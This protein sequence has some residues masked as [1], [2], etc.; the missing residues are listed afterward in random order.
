MRFGRGLEAA[1]S[2]G[3]RAGVVAI[4]RLA[5][6]ERLGVAERLG[7][8]ERLASAEHLGVEHLAAKSNAIGRRRRRLRMFVPI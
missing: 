3:S 7:F 6:G 8:A 4:E 2:P 1:D 5:R